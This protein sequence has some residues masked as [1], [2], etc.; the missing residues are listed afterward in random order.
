MADELTPEEQHKNDWIKA[1]YET[2]GWSDRLL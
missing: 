2:M 1:E